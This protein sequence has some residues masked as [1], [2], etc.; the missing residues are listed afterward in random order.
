MYRDDRMATVWS[1][2]EGNKIVEPI[3]E[4]RLSAHGGVAARLKMLTY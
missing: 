4:K 3:S 1:F 2:K